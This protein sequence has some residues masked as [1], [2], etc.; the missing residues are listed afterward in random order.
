MQLYRRV[1]AAP[2]PAGALSVLDLKNGLLLPV[3]MSSLALHLANQ[4]AS[5]RS[6]HAHSVQPCL[7]CILWFHEEVCQLNCWAMSAQTSLQGIMRAAE[8]LL[9]CISTN[10]CL[11]QWW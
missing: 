6:L 1:R 10:R 4:P 11:L 3:D 2:L 8:L 7:Q 5:Q 9:Q